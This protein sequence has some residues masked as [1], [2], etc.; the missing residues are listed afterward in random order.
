MR[1][2]MQDNEDK[3]ICALPSEA[4]NSDEDRRQECR[5]KLESKGYCYLSMVGWMCRREKIRRKDDDIC[6]W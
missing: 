6:G 1:Q 4:K 5:R 2:A 3:P